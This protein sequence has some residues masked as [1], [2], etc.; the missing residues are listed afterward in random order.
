VKPS[1][2]EVGWISTGREEGRSFPLSAPVCS[3]SPEDAE[4]GLLSE[5]EALGIPWAKIIAGEIL[6]EGTLRRYLPDP[7]SD[8]PLWRAIC[9]LPN[10][11]LQSWRVRELIDRLSLEAS[12]PDS[13]DALRELK[14]LDEH[15]RG[16]RA[17]RTTSD[18][19]MAKHLWFAYHRILELHDIARAASKSRGDYEARIRAV[20]SRTGCR[21]GDAEWGIR[22]TDSAIPMR[23]LEEAV[24]KTREEGFDIPHA[25]TEFESFLLVRKFIRRHPLFRSSR[26]ERASRNGARKT[27]R[28]RLRLRREL[29]AAAGEGIDRKPPAGR[30]E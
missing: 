2:A 13:A 23:P 5:A 30:Q 8:L 18:A 21:R 27:P 4:R 6:A 20:C 25:A 3:R 19:I 14:V 1:E 16:C 28:V 12:L 17:R 22:R 24:S 15:L 29:R 10:S 9:I 11:L 26:R 7:H